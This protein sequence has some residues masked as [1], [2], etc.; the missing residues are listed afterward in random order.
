MCDFRCNLIG[1]ECLITV[2]DN[3]LNLIPESKKK[4][5][6]EKRNAKFRSLPA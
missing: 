4:E 3:Y 1:L 5:Y 6:E 2:N